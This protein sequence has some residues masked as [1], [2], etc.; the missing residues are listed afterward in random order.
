VGDFN[1]VESLDVFAVG[2]AQGLSVLVLADFL[3]D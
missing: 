3:A 1:V 2:K